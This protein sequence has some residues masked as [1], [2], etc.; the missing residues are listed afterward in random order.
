MLYNKKRMLKDKELLNKQN[1]GNQNIQ[2]ISYHFLSHDAMRNDECTRNLH[3]S[4]ILIQVGIFIINILEGWRYVPLFHSDQTLSQHWFHLAIFLFDS[5][6]CHHF[7]FLLVQLNIYS[8][9]SLYYFFIHFFIHFFFTFYSFIYLSIF[10]LV[11]FFFL[12][13]RSVSCT[14]T[15]YSTL[16]FSF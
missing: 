13:K 6:K 9:H 1:L 3:L 10:L 15:H 5:F 8:C 7:L 2:L 12:C 14:I 11:C 16:A 4:V